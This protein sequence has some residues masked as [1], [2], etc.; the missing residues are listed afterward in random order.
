MDDRH[1]NLGEH[2]T[3]S[4]ITAVPSIPAVPTP[5]TNQPIQYH[6]TTIVNDASRRLL[7]CW[8]VAPIW[9][10]ALIL[11]ACLDVQGSRAPQMIPDT[12]FRVA[13]P[14]PAYEEYP[15]PPPLYN[16]SDRVVEE[17]L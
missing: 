8:P 10:F 16:E 14:P 15:I 6:L 2:H 17:A 11:A 3:P 5:R 1:D 13:D 9:R 4:P 12:P 7:S